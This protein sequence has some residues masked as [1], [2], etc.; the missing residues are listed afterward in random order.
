MCISWG[1]LYEQTNHFVAASWNSWRAAAT[2]E[3][4]ADRT[5]HQKVLEGFRG[6]GAGPVPSGPGQGGK[7]IWR[8]PEMGVPPKSPKI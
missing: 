6:G 4:N 1:D 7:S 5:P 8:F 2:E 3:K